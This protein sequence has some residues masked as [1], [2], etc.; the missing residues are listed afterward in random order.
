MQLRILTTVAVVSLAL[1][2]ILPSTTARAVAI[3]RRDLLGGLIPVAPG[4]PN[5]PSTPSPAPVTTSD[6]PP[7]PKPSPPAVDPP[8]Q[9]TPAP[10]PPPPPPPPATTTDEPV[11]PTS[12]QPPSNPA[13]SNPPK[14]KPPT[15]PTNT[16]GNGNG[17][18]NGGQTPQT[19][20]SN[21]NNDDT[22][23]SPTPASNNSGGMT[24]PKTGQVKQQGISSGMIAV[25]V[26]AVL[27]V[28]GAVL[29]SCY[30][31]R[32][33][34]RRRESNFDEDILKHVPG[35]NNTT[36]TESGYGLYHGNAAGV[37]GNNM[38]NDPWRKNLDVYH[39][40]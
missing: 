34:K 20:D 27:A 32:Q 11:P 13:P 25:V 8:K 18:G 14:K 16:K 31:V 2:S 29:F 28:I 23:A 15:G 39:R 10:P 12:S 1:V 33:A 37:I 17:N 5:A 9:P 40:E 36:Y 7:A 30:R 6:T 26:L 38:E 22:T 19:D 21:N 4:P 24:D 3:D 35:G